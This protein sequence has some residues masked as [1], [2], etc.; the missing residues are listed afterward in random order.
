M[1]RPHPPRKQATASRGAVGTFKGDA[2]TRKPMTAAAVDRAARALARHERRLQT[3]RCL[4]VVCAVLAAFAVVVS[5]P[6]AIALA[7]GAG[8]EAVVYVVTV[9]RRRALIARLAVEPDAYG[10]AA[11]RE[12]GARLAGPGQR[13]RLGRWLVEVLD[14]AGRPESLYLADRVSEYAIQIQAVAFD[15]MAPDARV[16]PVSVATCRRLLT[17]AT[18]SPLYNPQLPAVDLGSALFRIHAGISGPA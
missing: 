15:L 2:P 10:I 3:G 8:F 16:Q 1:R 13:E 6:L 17:V 5:P 12:F 9:A 7:L 14:E 11:V 4:T 18:E